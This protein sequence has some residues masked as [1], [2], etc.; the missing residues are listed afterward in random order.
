MNHLDRRNY[1]W[2]LAAVVVVFIIGAA[3][4]PRT[5][6]KK[7]LPKPLAPAAPEVA[8]YTEEPT[9]SLYRHQLGGTI[10]ELPLEKYLEGVV[11]AEVGPNP[12]M[13]ALKAQAIVARTLTLALVNYQNGAP[14]PG[15][16]A[17][18][19]HTHFQAYDEKKVTD[20]IRQAVAATRGQVLTYDGKFIY[21]EFHSCAGGKTA[22]I[23]EAFPK[24][25]EAASDY[26]KPVSSPGMR[27]ASRNERYWSL[28]L[29]RWELQNIMG[30]EAGSLND[31]KISK[32]G[33]SGRALT[34]TAGGKDISAIDLRASLGPDRFKSTFI[35]SIRPRGDYIY[36][37]GKGWGHGAGMEQWGAFGLAKQGKSA[38]QIVTHYY[39]DAQLRTL[40]K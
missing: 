39:T 8:Q 13:E 2:I 25:A 16:D 11:A 33:P 4:Y 36:F 40:W 34:L 5:Q 9:I 19:L 6:V 1:A 12:P 14:E 22:S 31:L 7:P 17:C 3:L 37:K 18:D 23:E 29:P 35:T 27:Y 38:Q 20:R 24:L 21:A 15:A 30:S 10:Q 28:K 26:I 32:R